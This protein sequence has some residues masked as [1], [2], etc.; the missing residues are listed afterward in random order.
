M[1]TKER[2]FLISDFQPLELWGHA[3]PLLKL[4]DILLQPALAHLDFLQFVSKASIDNKL[5]S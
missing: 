3:F 5:S 4:P 1:Q 2:G